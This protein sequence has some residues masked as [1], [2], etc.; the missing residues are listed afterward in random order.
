MPYPIM[1]YKLI[2][3]TFFWLKSISIWGTIVS[4][5]TMQNSVVFDGVVNNVF[6]KKFDFVITAFDALLGEEQFSPDLSF[7][8]YTFPGSF[9]FL[10]CA[11]D[12]S[13]VQTISTIRFVFSAA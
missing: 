3:D 10:R 6:C 11:V 2:L 4:L 13:S 8:L 7:S 12:S 9:L 1:T 5:Y